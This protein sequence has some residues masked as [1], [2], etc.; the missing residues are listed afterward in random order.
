MQKYAKTT[1]WLKIETHKTENSKIQFPQQPYINQIA[2]TLKQSISSL[3][4]N[5]DFT[6][7]EQW[8]CIMFGKG[9]II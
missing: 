7:H 9:A 5:V 1:L 2:L 8:S 6:T 4:N 3:P